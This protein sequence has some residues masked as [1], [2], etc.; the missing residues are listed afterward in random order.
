MLVFCNQWSRTLIVTS[1]ALLIASMI[2]GQ[3]RPRQSS[4]TENQ[5]PASMRPALTSEVSP[6]RAKDLLFATI[7]TTCPVPGEGSA[8]VFFYDDMGLKVGHTGPKTLFEYRN[9]RVMHSYG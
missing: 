9:T 7:L 1:G 8:A 3:S 6:E 2:M 5:K 4:P